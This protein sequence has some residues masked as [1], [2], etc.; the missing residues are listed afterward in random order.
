MYLFY[1]FHLYLIRTFITIWIE[2]MLELIQT[3]GFGLIPILN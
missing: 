1:I 3:V 2:V